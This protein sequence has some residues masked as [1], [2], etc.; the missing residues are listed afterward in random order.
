[1]RDIDANTRQALNGSRVGDTITV[2]AW[3]DGSLAYPAPLDVSSWS[4]GWDATRQIQSMNI[5]IDDSSGELAPWLLEDVLGVAG[6]QLQVVYNV[7]G[8]GSV[9]MG[10]WRVAESDPDENWLPYLIPARGRTNPGSAIPDGVALVLISGGVRIPLVCDDL[11]VDIS[12]NQFLAPDSPQGTSPTILSEIG[13]L[14]DGIVP[15]VTTAGVVDRSVNKTLIYQ[16]DRLAAV[17]DLCHRISCDY[18][19]NGDGQFEVYPITP[20][21]PVWLIRGG[22]EGVQVKV[23]RSMK[24]DGL[25]NVFVAD[26]TATVNGQ[27]TPIRGI[28]RIDAGPLR[29]GGPHGTYPMFYQS[30]MLTTQAQ[31]DAYAVTMRDTQLRGLTIDLL[32]ECA[33]HPALQQGDWVTVYN[34]LV[35]GR[36]M[37]LNGKVKTMTLKSNGN[38]VDRMTLTVECSY[39][40]VQAALAAPES[41]SMVGPFGFRSTHPLYPSATTWPAYSTTPGVSL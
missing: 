41:V 20:Q 32:V 5:E 39:T 1:M 33:P 26:G 29:A 34:A 27:Q 22:P 4:M 17:Q 37:P 21:T 24:L 7:G 19:M 16:Q 2:W 18:R 14:L 11:A 30:T 8:A 15:V 23:N 10:W 35:G 9:N 31:C 38:T 40:D 13:R 36:V 28:A 12:H 6:T 25:Y 3:Y